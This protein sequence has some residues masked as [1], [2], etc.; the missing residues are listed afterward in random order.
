MVAKPIDS[1]TNLRFKNW[2]T[3][4]DKKT[5]QTGIGDKLK[6]FEKVFV[7]A[8]NDLNELGRAR[9]PEEFAAAKKLG[10]A[11]AKKVPA[12]IKAAQELLTACK[13]AQSKAKSTKDFPKKSLDLIEQ[14][15]KDSANAVT[16][17]T[18]RA[19]QMI[20][21]AINSLNDYEKRR[22][23]LAEEMVRLATGTEK[24]SRQA[25]ALE[26]R[27]KLMVSAAEQAAKKKDAPGAR[28]AVAACEKIVED[29]KG[30]FQQSE[31]LTKTW[32]LSS[33]DMTNFL[34]Q[35]DKK[36][37][38]IPCSN[39]I[40]T[41]NK[42]IKTSQKVAEESTVKARDFFNLAADPMAK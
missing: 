41:A 33:G 28:K 10:E 3:Q 22:K 30:L 29:I 15:I 19:P 26:Q 23:A 21:E 25:E 18:T 20:N 34:S 11:A 38:V 42:E 39:R 7:P 5:P 4:K 2:D 36:A 6:A 1:F 40:M 35:N 13:T 37:V 24:L 14:Y 31:E 8:Q 27:S 16:A 9:G 12:V 32:R 17:F